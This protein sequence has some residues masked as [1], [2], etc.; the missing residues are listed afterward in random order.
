MSTR[1][2]S[3][4]EAARTAYAQMYERI[5]DPANLATVFHCSAGKDRTGWAAASFLSLLGVPQD[6]VF[7][8]YLLSNDYLAESTAHTLEQV[9]GLIDPALLE[10]VLGVDAEYL[11]ASFDTVDSEYG[12]IDGYFTEGLG[13]DQATIDQLEKEF[14]AG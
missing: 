5:A 4:S 10:P 7:E 12:S 8:D 11:Q 1:S 14:L 2:R 3:A 13:L 9:G 6:V